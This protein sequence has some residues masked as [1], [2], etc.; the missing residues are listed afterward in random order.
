M[1]LPPAFTVAANVLEFDLVD[2][3]NAVAARLVARWNDDGVTLPETVIVAAAQSAGQGRG[4]NRWHSPQGGAYVTWVSEVNRAE[5]AIA[6]LAAGVA[7]LEAISALVGGE[8]LRLKWPND[9]LAGGRKLA[10][11]LCQSRVQGGRVWLVVG[12]GVNVAAA[13]GPR[14][15]FALPPTSLEDLGFA[16]SVE[17][18]VRALVESFVPRLRSGLDEPHRVSSRWVEHS[19]HRM[20]DEMR[21]RTGDGSFTGVFRGLTADGRLEIEIGGAVRAIAVGELVVPLVEEGG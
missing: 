10:G 21:V 18:A 19:L 20:G 4:N 11:V 2:S 16:G 7:L 15:T 14:D 8:G 5:L 6:P 13:L 17:S 12:V 9:V 3:T 1:S